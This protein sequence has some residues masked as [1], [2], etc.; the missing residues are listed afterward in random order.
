MKNIARAMGG[1]HSLDS[2]KPSGSPIGGSKLPTPPTQAKPHT[3]PCFGDFRKNVFLVLACLVLFRSDLHF[4]LTTPIL[5]KLG[6]ETH[7]TSFRPTLS[8]MATDLPEGQ[9]VPHTDLIA[10]E[11]GG[12]YGWRTWS[13]TKQ[14]P[15]WLASPPLVSL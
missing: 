5:K 14:S 13:A 8:D 3:A 12:S 11:P 1:S 15:A 2:E 6:L 7:V 4:V 9:N 10:A